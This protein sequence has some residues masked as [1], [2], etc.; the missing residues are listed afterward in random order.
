[1]EGGI[2]R[3]SVFVRN[4]TAFY[5]GGAF[6]SRLYNCL[7]IT[8]TATF[9]G[10]TYGGEL[11]NCTLIGNTATNFGGGIYSSATYN[12]IVYYN[13]AKLTGSNYQ[14]GGILI[15]CC[16]T[17]L[18]TG[19]GAG[20]CFTNQPVF[21][22]LVGGD[23][24]QQPISRTINGGL[25]LYVTNTVMG[26]ITN[27]F[28]GN[29]RI[30]GGAVD[31]GAY[32]YQGSNSGVP[33][34]PIPWLRQYGLST[35]G[36]ADFIDTDGDG[37]NNWQEWIAGTNPTNAVSLLKMLS[38]SNSP[39]GATVFWQSSP[40]V[41][42]Y[43]QSTTNPGVQPFTSI[44]SNLVGQFASTYFIDASATNGGSMLYRV[45]VQ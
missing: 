21:V 19:T 25:I 14:S 34:P 15:G 22:N 44:Q 33:Y 24:H 4:A 35:D 31:V 10:G 6:E 43:I 37:M 16:T 1:M 32:E 3:D 40:Q 9:G 45:G 12:S 29:P 5:G 18:P 27:D 36:S 7:V 30:V 42:Y 20:P 11:F 41:T 26:V 28:D 8:N 17:P 2:A 13:S 38:V 23:F 39:A